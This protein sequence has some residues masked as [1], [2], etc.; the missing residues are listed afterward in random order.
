MTCDIH[1]HLFGSVINVSQSHCILLTLLDRDK[2]DTKKT[3]LLIKKG[4]TG[5]VSTV[6]GT[7]YS[8][9]F[10]HLFI[11]MFFLLVLYYCCK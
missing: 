10:L 4:P 8:S 3:L 11:L 2:Q 9:S 7:N 1:F 6:R 5:Q